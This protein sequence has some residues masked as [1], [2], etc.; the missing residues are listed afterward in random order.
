MALCVHKKA[1]SA[2]ESLP[3]AFCSTIL[4]QKTLFALKA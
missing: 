2:L 1:V 4:S 3:V